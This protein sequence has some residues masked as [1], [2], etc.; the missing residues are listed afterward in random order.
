MNYKKLPQD[1]KE[2]LK[3]FKKNTDAVLT[4]GNMRL[5]WIPKT[6]AG[7]DH[8]TFKS[9]YALVKKSINGSKTLMPND[10]RFSALYANAIKAIKNQIKKEKISLEIT[11]FNFIYVYHSD[12]IKT[13]IADVRFVDTV[14]K[15]S[16]TKLGKSE[17]N[18]CAV[19]A[20]AAATGESYENTHKLFKKFGRKDNAGTRLSQIDAT[21]KT[22]NKKEIKK[23]YPRKTLK[24]V[25]SV[26]KT[27]SYVV[28]VRGHAFSI[29]NGIVYGNG[30]QDAAALRKIVKC[31]IEL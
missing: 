7:D 6:V 13:T 24:R 15:Y 17:R 23:S 25:L 10:K 30:A 21:I 27:G 12:N 5:S 9:V 14:E 1:P 19:R 22:I 11:T 31:V 26:T 2:I 8:D 28:L 16:K 18:D 20:V 29:V 3:M 4:V